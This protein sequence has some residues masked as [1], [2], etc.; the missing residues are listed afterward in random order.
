MSIPNHTR[1][2]LSSGQAAIGMGVRLVRTQE[3]A[4][5]MTEAGFDWL[6]IDLEHGCASIESASQICAAALE[7]GITPIARVP[8]GD[9]HL[10]TRL[11]DNGAL[12]IVMPCIDSAEDARAFV[13]HIR[14][15]P[16]GR[17]SVGPPGPQQRYQASNLR[18]VTAEMNRETLAIALVES[19]RGVDEANEIAAVPG[20]DV[21][22]IGPGDLSLELEIANDNSR[23]RLVACCRKV[24]EACRAQG[25]W[26]GTGSMPDA[27]LLSGAL[28]DGA[29]FVLLAGDTSLL[30]EAAR[31]K[32]AAFHALTNHLRGD[33]EVKG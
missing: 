11:L 9:Y 30:L 23:D 17:R 32:A 13:E 29:R 24:A 6:F 10:A 8:K 25:K 18:E 7:C 16:A 3:I 21:L 33:K 4:R 19:V 20:I 31:N 15:P 28:A 2:K 14:F 5:L 1:E 12:G 26:F 27:D 22:M